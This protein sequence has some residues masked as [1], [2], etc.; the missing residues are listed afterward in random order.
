MSSLQMKNSLCGRPWRGRHVAP[1]EQ[2]GERVPPQRHRTAARSRAPPPACRSCPAAAG[3]SGGSGRRSKR[4]CWPASRAGRGVV[5]PGRRPRAAAPGRRAGEPCRRPSATA[6]P[7]RRRPPPSGP[8]GSRRRRPRCGRGGPPARRGAE[9]DRSRGVPSVLALSTTS[10]WS[11]GRV[12]PSTA[13]RHSSSRRR[14]LRVTTTAQ[15]VSGGAVMAAGIPYLAPVP[16]R[17]DTTAR[18]PRVSLVMP[19]RDNAPLL[20]LVL[21]RLAE[22]TTY[23]DVELVVVDDGSTDGSLEILQALARLGPLRGLQADRAR[24]RRRGG[25]AER[26]PGGGHRRAGGAARRRRVRGDPGLAGA[27]GGV[28][29]DRRARG[30]RDRE[31][32]LRPGRG[33]RLR[34]RSG[35]PRGPARPRH[36]DHRAGGPAA[37]PPA[38][39]AAQGRATAMPASARPRWTAASAAA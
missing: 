13:A 30:G 11:G 16:P 17:P 22:N 10:T 9:C 2:R 21:D 23:A 20:D 3:S 37:L 12:W 27:D 7:S 8:R 19:N 26:R 4:P 36:A 33:P 29:A 6:S 28:H 15:T 32:G 31:G 5:Q 25:G 24:A 14:R 39:A 38:G 1:H 34:D 35:G 18:A